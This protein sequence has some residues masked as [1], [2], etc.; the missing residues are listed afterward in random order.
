MDGAT[1]GLVV[2]LGLLAV[3]MALVL[4]VAAVGRRD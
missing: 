4:A 2:S 1:M 3:P